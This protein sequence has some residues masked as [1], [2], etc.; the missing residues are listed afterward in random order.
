MQ[1]KSPQNLTQSRLKEL[2]HYDPETGVF[3]R[4]T[5]RGGCASGTIAGTPHV[6]GYRSLYVDRAHYLAH[7]LSF[8]YM[9]GAFPKGDVDHINGVR[10]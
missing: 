8:L 7:R 2:L 1:D 9:T 4:R 3:T 10:G 6:A 5:T